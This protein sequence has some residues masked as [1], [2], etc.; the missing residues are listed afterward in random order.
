MKRHLV[1][2]AAVAAAFAMESSCPWA[3]AATPADKGVPGKGSAP[4]DSAPADSASV[5]AAALV[6]KALLAEVAGNL[7]ARADALRQAVTIAPE[8][9]PAHWQSGEVK[10][11]ERWL[12]VEDA[13]RENE[14]SGKFLSYQK[15][16]AAAPQTADGQMALARWCKEQG[17]VEQEK[18]HLA[19][20]L[21]LAPAK[22][23][24]AEVINK[25]GFVRYRHQL[26]PAAT[27]EVLKKQAKEAEAALAKWKPILTRLR[28][29]LES[30]DKNRQETARTKLKE[31]QD[32]A[33]IP[34]L[35]AVFATARPEIGQAAIDA[36]VALP[37]QAATD[38]LVR[39]A[40][41]AK[42]DGMRQAAAVAL[43]ERDFFTFVPFLLS[44][45]QMPIEV[46]FTASPFH[47][48]LSLF[49]EGPLFN[50]SY[51]STVDGQPYLALL[52]VLNG[53]VLGPTMRNPDMAATSELKDLAVANAALEENQRV[54]LV[55]ERVAQVL[56]GATGNDFDS[57]PK[58]WWDWWAQFN[59]VNYAQEKPTYENAR[60]NLIPRSHSCFVPGTLVWTVTGT[61]AIENV[62][63]GDWVL[64]Q[65]VDS[66][67][68]TYKPVEAV[69]HGTPLPLVEICIGQQTIRATHGHLFWVVGTG[70]RMA[71][72]LKVGDRLHTTKGTLTIDTVEK[73]GEAACHNLVVR[74]FNTYFVTDAMILVHDIEIRGPTTAIV[75]GLT[76]E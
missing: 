40:L 66:G 58:G 16:R 6:R 22:G 76:A 70:W 9:A 57:D 15:S 55:N 33:I 41:F 44:N 50:S 10:V 2:W 73:T 48:R 11:G 24:R 43:K 29:D 3:Y 56:K 31:S 14:W 26:M 20:A 25:L 42:H 12:A 36:L 8:F 19:N 49:R 35:E 1:V 13:A 52:P 34:A 72:E 18:I 5:E 68:L 27:A 28:G 62:Q 74:D 71:K 21:R 61:V 64:S 75:P 17:L 54:A 67:E 30:R 47:S 39:F 59:E 63:V 38:S 65:N 32:P 37:Q 23:K 69:T 7:Q 51:T 53:A 45:M 46:S 4:T 60:Y